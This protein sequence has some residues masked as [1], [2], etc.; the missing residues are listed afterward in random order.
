[1]KGKRKFTIFNTSRLP[2]DRVWL[3][4]VTRMCSEHWQQWTENTTQRRAS[5]GPRKSPSYAQ[6]HILYLFTDMSRTQTTLSVLL[7]TYYADVQL[8]EAKVWIQP[9][10]WNFQAGWIFL[11]VVPAIITT[12]DSHRWSPGCFQPGPFVRQ[13]V[14]MFRCSVTFRRVPRFLLS[15][16]K[17]G[18][19]QGADHTPTQAW[20]AATTGEL[21]SW[22]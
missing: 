9:F 6:A 12:F 1:M 20:S 16:N 3:Q 22:V 14:S 7:C 21:V 13:I 5:Q 4:R 15:V 18:S 17:E 19:L 8:S 2:D 11:A 10:A